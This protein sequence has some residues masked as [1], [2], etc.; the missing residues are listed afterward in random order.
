MTYPPKGIFESIVTTN[1]QL[2]SVEVAH[3]TNGST[4]K[5]TTTATAAEAKLYDSEQIDERHY[6]SMTETVLTG[7]Q[8][9][10][11]SFTDNDDSIVDDST[12]NTTQS[13][14]TT[15]SDKLEVDMTTKSHNKA[16]IVPPTQQQ[17]DSM[18]ISSVSQS[19]KTI[20]DQRLKT[21]ETLPST[22]VWDRPI[23]DSNQ[24]CSPTQPN[25]RA[26]TSS[27]IDLTDDHS[28]S[29]DNFPDNDDWIDWSDQSQLKFREIERISVHEIDSNNRVTEHR[30]NGVPIVLTNH[31]GWAQFAQRWLIPINEKEQETSINRNETALSNNGAVVN[32]K[33]SYNNAEQMLD[34]SKPHEI[35]FK[36]LIEDIGSEVV[37][38]LPR[39][40]DE[41]NPTKVKMP[42][43]EFLFQAWPGM[44]DDTRKQLN[45]C[46]TTCTPWYLHQWQFPL[47]TNRDIVSMLCGHGKNNPLPNN[48][49]GDDLLSYWLDK[50]KCNCDSPYQYLFMGRED[51]KSKL[52][53]DGGGLIITIAPI[54]GLKEVVLVHRD[55]G[56]KLY[57]MEANI[58]EVNLDTH[59][60][61][62]DVRAWKSTIR[63]GEILIMPEGT[64]H[65]CRNVTPCFSYHRFYLDTVNLPSFLNSHYTN[66]AKEISHDEVIWNAAHALMRRIDNH[67]E[68]VQM[69][70]AYSIVT[71]ALPEK[72]KDTIC[73][74]RT[75]RHISCEFLIRLYSK[76]RV[77]GQT[78][79][80]QREYNYWNGLIFDIDET[81]HTFRYRYEKTLPKFIQTSQ[82]RCPVSRKQRRIK[83]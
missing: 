27:L 51:T 22:L 45:E 15:P 11:L 26:R 5:M 78:S 10:L 32:S 46:N 24:N 64:Y 35:N 17:Q 41:Y 42:V 47:S 28:D 62:Y 50:A 38:V 73:N 9:D 23:T 54:I 71:T 43:E 48:I 58:D 63:P 66:D 36:Q 21:I 19:D 25:K 80:L 39:Q 70:Q 13:R 65:Q 74:L 67:I 14:L 77:R 53:R 1:Q 75:M 59:P 40:Y 8:S 31:V 30:R 52:H 34:L 16:F 20:D 12:S 29:C 72:V 49:L 33:D 81:L 61:M 6:T 2:N 56:S 79:S 69:A 37:P 44:K 3:S 68:F 57:N 60:M 83:E 4:S 18:F 55:C 76:T 7:N 82:W